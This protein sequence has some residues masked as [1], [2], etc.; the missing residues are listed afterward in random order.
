MQATR[1]E[2]VR[3]GDT[4]D[5]D[6]GYQHRALTEGFVVQRFWHRLKT[7][8]IERV[9]PPEPEMAVLDLGC[10]S[11]VVADWLAARARAVDAVDANP[12]AVEYARKTF[13]RGNLT[14]HLASA[15]ALPFPAESFDRVYVLEFIEHLYGG[16][17]ASLFAS[18]RTLLRPGGTVFLT[19]P[20]YRSPWPL[21]EG[22]MDRLGL[23]P[24][25]EGEQHV[26]HPTPRLLASLAEE[27]GFAVVRQGRFAGAAPFAAAA[28][29]RLAEALDRA[30]HRLGCPLGSLLYA[31]WRK[32]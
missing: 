22:A 30:E 13:A 28:S 32:A 31:L 7:I 11:G 9:A 1:T 29:W 3:T 15:D 18:L 21:L 23:A 14:F 2:G 19:T 16:Q 17:L 26:S 24:H 27:S 10:G 12:R 20:N 4:I 25:M 6:G 8:T 5:I